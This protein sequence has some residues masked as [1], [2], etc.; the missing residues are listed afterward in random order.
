MQL[1][2]YFLNSPSKDR[3]GHS[4]TMCC[5]VCGAPQSQSGS[6]VCPHLN[7]QSLH[8]PTPVR[9]RFNRTHSFRGSLIPGTS[10]VGS[11]T[12]ALLVP[13]KHCHLAVHS[14]SGEYSSAQS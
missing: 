13:L 5:M 9:K 4:S 3:K 1:C 7:L 12:K 2:V 11:S 8:L 6:S 10:L 14:A